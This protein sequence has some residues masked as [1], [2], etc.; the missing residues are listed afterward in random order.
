MP[1]KWTANTT[2]YL[3]RAPKTEVP[4]VS[5]ELF[6]PSNELAKKG[7][8]SALE[9][10]SLLKPEFVS[11]T[12]GAGGS[13]NSA[14]REAISLVKPITD[15][16]PAPHVTCINKSKNQVH[17][18]VKQYLHDG[19]NQLVAL[20]GDISGTGVACDDSYDSALGLVRGIRSLGD[21]T[22]SVAAYPEGHPEA[23]SID[24]EIAYLKKKVD[25]GANQIITQFFFDTE[26][27][28][29]FIER[30]RDAGIDVPVIPGILPINHF[31]R[32][33][34]F[35]RKCGIKIPHWYQVMYKDLEENPALHNAISTSIAVEQCRQLMAFGVKQFH[36]YTLNQSALT[37]SVC[38]ELGVLGVA[39]PNTA[40]RIVGQV[41]GF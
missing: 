3:D 5:I 41:S 18:E 11:V 33:V 26:V 28:V 31:E 7:F 23:N 24:E 14:T 22:I 12:C 25:A 34:S 15:R 37:L 35:S 32:A 17:A 38:K 20:R 29:Q 10:L 2:A 1:S 19:V 39:Q 8:T 36:F 4:S 40:D 16:A 6:P 9:N 30:V 27:F 13:Q 21:F